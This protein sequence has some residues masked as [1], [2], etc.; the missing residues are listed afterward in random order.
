M[1]RTTTLIIAL[2]LLLALALIAA[3]FIG[4]KDRTTG[5]APPP[6]ASLGAT[7][8]ERGRALVTLA[9]CRPCH[10]AQGD[11][12]FAGGRA[13]PTP[14]GTFYSPNITP[15]RQ[16]GIGE[17]TSEDFWHALHNGYS[18]DGRPLYP[19][20]P[21]T[22]YTKISRRDAQDMYE[23]LR[24]VQPVRRAARPHVLEFPYNNEW[25]LRLWR[26]AYF[27]PGVYEP[28]RS[29]SAEWNR[30]AYIVE[31]LAHCSA[32]HEARNSLGA[33]RAKG[34]PAGGLVL[35]WYAPSLALTQEA[36]LQ[37]WPQAEIAAFLASGRTLGAANSPAHCAAAMGPMAEVIY[38]SLQRAPAHELNAM[39]AYLKSIPESTA[40]ALARAPVT[41]TDDDPTLESG[42]KNYAKHCARCHGDNGEGRPPAALPLAG[43]RAVTMSNATNTARIV[44][45]GGYPPGTA[46]NPRP[47]GMP[48]FADTL[49]NVEIAEILTF[50]RSAWGNQASAVTA[51]D[52]ARNRTGPQW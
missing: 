21:Y 18:R 37:Q 34:N 12:D 28:D 52:V 29:R 45:Y 20:F 19:T 43:N 46:S 40:A 10:T 24:T 42:R 48:P 11:A 1:R 22:N 3:L 50:V 39:A 27:R 41:R 23:Y 51:N 7:S 47:F 30:G 33:A 32:C 17:W 2:V 9:D 6:S 44:L 8:I 49:S 14:F 36:G 35:N 38:E 31:G 13:I 5:E 16:T 26:R 15:D 25:L 4:P